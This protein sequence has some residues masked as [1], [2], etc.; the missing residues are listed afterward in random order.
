MDNQD[1]QGAVAI[2]GVAGRFSE[3]LDRFDAG[4]FGINHREAE[5]LD[6]QQRV[7]LEACWEALEDAGYGPDTVGLTGVFAGQPLSSYLLYNLLPALTDTLSGMDPLQLLV[8]N[9]A[10]SLAT[11]VSYKLN[12][13]GPSFTVQ[14]GE[15]TLGLAVHL[16]R[17]SLLNGECDLALAGWVSIDARTLEG[18][19]AVLVLK[20]AD[21]AIRD[22]D[23]VQGLVLDSSSDGLVEIEQAPEIPR[24]RSD[25]ER[26]V[27]PVSAR[28]PE[29][30]EWACQ[31]LAD[32][33]ETRPEVELADV[34][35]TL[36][37]GRK[38]FEH[39]RVVE[40]GTTQDAVHALR[41]FRG[42]AGVPPA[43]FLVGA[44]GTPALPGKARRISL[45]T[46]PFER[47]RY[48][49]EPQPESSFHPRPALFTPYEPPRDE[50][51][52][53][54]AA[55][56]QEVLGVAPVGAHDDFF[57]LGGHSLL[58][59]QIL[60]RVRDVFGV[61]FPL[62]HVFS[63][64]T[65]AEL[66][67]AIR[68]L[69]TEET[70]IPVSPRRAAGGPYPL[71]FAQERLWFIDRLDPGSP[72]YN[73]PRTALVSG[74]LDVPRFAAAL[75]EL[76]RRQ[77]ALRTTFQ[78]IDGEP[79]QVV[80]PAVDLVLPLVDLSALSE[81]QK[82]AE[83]LTAEEARRPFDLERGPVLRT[84][85]VRLKP[86]EHLV[87]FTVHH[88][89]SDGWS[90]DLLVGEVAALYAGNPLPE[91]PIQ[92][93]DYAEWQRGW[94]QDEVLEPHLAHWREALAGAP[95]VLEL[96]TDRPRPAVPSYRGGW[97]RM[98]LPGVA[99]PL[100]ELGRHEGASRF[101]TLLA[102]FQ[103]LLHRLTGQDDLLVGS[104]VAN[105][106][107]PEIEGLVGFFVNLLP[108]RARF[109]GET[110][111]RGLLGQVRDGAL[112]AYEHQDAPF[113]RVVE[114]VG[115][116]RDLSR[117]PLVQVL[118]L[119]QN[120]PLDSVHLPGLTL[121]A[122]EVHAGVARYDLS[123]FA[124]EAGGELAAAVEYSS[125]LF[126]AATV[127]RL[128]GWLGVLLRGA[129]AEPDASLSDLPLLD[130]AE[131]QQL[132]AEWNDAGERVEAGIVLDLFDGWVERT[133]E[134]P[135]VVSDEGSVTYREL[136]RRA[137]SLARHLRRL[138]VGP[139]TVIALQMERSPDLVTAALGV[140]R[141]GAAYLPL[142]PAYPAERL[143]WMVEDSGAK[144]R[145]TSIP[146]TGP[147]GDE[148]L[149]RPE[150][151]DLAYLIYTSG[152]T[153]RP[154]G[155]MVTH[156]GLPYLAAGQDRLL[157]VRPGDRVLQFSSPSFD[158]SVWE[159]WQALSH[160]AALVLGRRDELLPGPG[161]V[162]LLRRH[163]VTHATLPPS[164]LAAMPDGAEA[165]L[166]ALRTLCVA[167]EACPP[168]LARRWEA[169]RRFL[170]AYGPTEGTVC[171]AVGGLSGDRLPIGRPFA[172]FRL[173][174]VDARLAAVLIG[175]P[176]ELCLG[177]PGLA[178]GYLNR[179]DLTAERFIP[180]PFSGLSG[181]AGGRLYRTGDL[182]RRL[183]DG[184]LD[185]LGRIDHQV[186]IRGIRI[187]LGEIEAE[188]AAHP[189]VRQA[190][191]L[192]R[193]DRGERRL[194]AFVEA[195]PGALLLEADL[196][197]LLRGRLLEAMV[198]SAFVFLEALPVTPNG[199]VD[200]QA[201]AR[202]PV[203]RSAG[204]ST[205]ALTPTETVVA[206]I[207]SEL[208]GVG[209]VG[210]E[211]D[212]FALGGHS[213]LA[214]RVV[215]RIRDACGVELP[216]RALFEAPT[217]A[218]FAA[219][220]VAHDVLPAPPIQ[221]LPAEDRRAGLPL[222]FPQE[223]F[224]FLQELDPASGAYNITAAVRL[225]GR[226]DVA[227]LARAL[228]VLARRHEALRTVFRFDL[229]REEA[230]QQVL[231]GVEVRLPIVDLSGL[232]ELSPG[233][234]H[235]ELERLAAAAAARPFDL[236]RGPLLRATLVRLDAGEHALLLATHHIVSDGWSM[237][238]LVREVAA[239]YAGEPLPELP[240]QLGDYAVW[241]R[242]WLS[243]DV[244]EAQ[245]A[246][247]RREL[248][249]A[250]GLLDLPL[251]RPRP[252]VQSFRG[253]R[254]PV[255]L[256]AS[257]VQAL[258]ELGRARGATLFMVLLAGFQALLHRLS[259]QE[260]VLVGTPVANRDRTELE[261]LIGLLVNTLAL[262]ARFGPSEVPGFDPL[263]ERVRTTALGAFAH[264]DV[265][266]EKVLEGLRIERSLAFNP[267]FQHLF[268]LQTAPAPV[269]ALPG[270][271]LEPLERDAAALAWSKFDLSLSLAPMADGGLAGELEYAADLFDTS[272]V[273]HLARMYRT[274]LEA[275]AANPRASLDELVLL[276]RT[277][278]RQVRFAGS[279]EPQAK[280]MAAMAAMAESWLTEAIAGV[281]KDL[282]RVEH[283]GLSDNFF[284]LGGHSLLLPKLH[285]RLQEALGERAAGLKLADLFQFPTVGSLAAHLQGPGEE[286][287]PVRQRVALG[288]DRRIAIVGLAGRFHG[289]P[290]LNRFWE[291]LR[292]GV[293]SIRKLGREEL[294]IQGV[295]P[296]LIDDPAFVPVWSL[297]DGYD[298]FDARLFGFNPREAELLDPQHRVFLEVALEALE[299]AGWGDPGGLAV[300]VFAGT[301]A[302]AYL[303]R[304]LL[305]SSEVRSADPL[306]FMVGNIPDSLATRVSYKLDLQGPSYAVQSACSTS[307]LAVHAACQSLLMGECDMALAGGV[308]LP[309][310]PG[311]RH[312][313]NSI[314]SP[315]GHCRAFDAAALGTV[316]G[317]GAGAVV[318][319][320][321]EDAL[322]DGD[323]VR[324]VIL[325]SAVNNDGALKVGY[326][327]PSVEGQARVIAE[328]LATASVHPEEIAYVEAHG[329]ATPLGDTVEIAALTRAFRLRGSARSGYCAL[330]SVKS[331]LGHL[332]A[333][334]GVT[335][336]IK[337]VLSIEHG[338]IPPS[339][340]FARP[341]PQIDFEASPVYVNAG[342]QDWPRNGRPRRA[343][344]SSF[345]IGGTNVHIVLEE[346]PPAPARV[347]RE[348]EHLL[349]LSAHTASALEEVTARLARHLREHPDLDLGDVA[350]TLLQGRKAHR[351]RRT[352]R[353]RTLE[354]A[355]AA[356]ES[357]DPERVW[358]GV[359]EGPISEAGPRDGRRRIP[360]PTYP[361]ERERF[362]VDANVS[363]L[364]T[365]PSA[366][367][368]H[369]RP[370]LF[371][372]YVEPSTPAE[373]AVAAV[374]RE[375]LG[376]REV[377]VHDSFFEL[378][379]HSLL[380]TQVTA[381]LHQAFGVSLPLE[382]LF[383]H[384]TI[385]ELA[386]LLEGVA[387][388]EQTGVPRREP[389]AVLPLSFAQERLWFLDRLEPGSS[390]YNVPNAIRLT[391]DLDV[392]ALAAAL[393][394]VV[395]R[396]EMLRTAFREDA[397]GR[398]YQVVSGAVEL[399][400]P[401]IDVAPDELQGLAMAEA[402]RP[403]DL[404]RAPL[405]RAVLF[406]LGEREHVFLVTFH[407]VAADGWSIAVFVREIAAL[408]AGAELPELAVQYG[409]FALWQR[410]YL[411]GETLES[412]LRWWRGELAGAPAVLEL[413]ADRP[414][415]AEK[416]GRGALVPAG[417]PADLRASLE[418]LARREGATLFMV[419]LA[420]FQALL[421]RCNQ[422]DD[423]L[424]GTPVANR[425]L[426]ELEPIIGHF[427]NN[428]VMRGR[429]D[430][431]PDFR[432]L[433]GRTRAAALGAYDH[434]D[435]P[436]E[437]L[438]D[439]LKVERSLSHSPLFQVMLTLQNGPGLTL[440]LPGLAIEEVVFDPGIARY[441]LTLMLADGIGGGSGLT[442]T[443]E[444]DTDLFDPA[445]GERL[446]RHLH[447]LLSAVA[448]D[449]D[450]RLS[451]LPLLTAAERREVLAIGEA[452]EIPDLTVDRL[453]D[454]QADRTP[455]AVAVIQGET[456]LTYAGL[457]SRAEAIA[458]HLRSLGVGPEVRVGLAVDRTPDLLAAL[459]GIMK[460]GGAYVPLDLS[461][462]RERMAMIV[463][464]AKPAVILDQ[465]LLSSVE[466]VG[467]RFIA[468]S[469]LPD[470][471]AY[472]LFT[473]GS[474][475]RPKGVQIPHRAFVNFL[476]SM[477]REPG[478]SASD[479]LFAITTLSFDIAGL[480]LML[481]L[482]AGGR[483]ALATRDEAADA[484][485]LARRLDE[486]GAT[487][488]QATPATW[489]MLL[490]SDWEGKPDLAA[491]CGGEALPGE[492]AAR[493]RP[494]V[495]SLWNLY[496]PT[497]TTV[498]SAAG[499][500]ESPD[501]AL[502]SQPVGAPIAN[503]GLYVLDANREP[504][505]PGVPGELCIGGDGL[506]R[507]YV[508]RPELT[509]ER[510]VPD[511]FTGSGARMYRTG[512]LARRRAT[513][514][515]DF[516]GRIDH[517][518]KVRGFRIELGEIEAAL[519]SHP[520]VR[521]A[522]VLALGEGAEKTLTAYVSGVSS[523]DS[524]RAHLRSALPE[525]MIPSAF[526]FVESFPLNTNG[527][528]DRKA[529]AALKPQ[530]ETTAFVAPRTETERR[531]A[532]IWS[533]LL[534]AG[535]VGARD[536]FFDLGG[537]SLLGTQ[538]VSRVRVE[539]GVELPLRAL[540]EA[541]A[542]ADL[543][544]RIE[545]ARRS[546]LPP[547]PL[548]T[549][550][551]TGWPLSFAQE[552]LWFLD[553]LDAGASAYNVNSAVRL[554][555][556]LDVVRL[557][558]A[559]RAI[560]RR[561]EVLRT[562]FHGGVDGPVQVIHSEVDLAVPVIDVCGCPEEEIRRLSVEEAF[563]PFDLVHG[564]LMRFVLLRLG[565][566]EHLGLL[567]FHHIAADGWSTAVFLREV[568]ALYKGE[569]LPELAIQYA[570]FAVWQR[571]WLTGEVLEEQ[572]GWWRGE[573][574]GAPTVLDLPTDHP[575]PFHPSGRAWW[576]PA[577]L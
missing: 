15:S 225:R 423:V 10:D 218:G 48:W 64:P 472:I 541:P 247:W 258:Q 240:I 125:D 558:E 382:V 522:V 199:K 539:L 359:G 435:V 154:K 523:A 535:R 362:W 176:G 267:L 254:L 504:V 26:Y 394:A 326:S 114:A 486:V 493:L 41:A 157:D 540:F 388:E 101:M 337:T 36:T 46:Y 23:N 289:A 354:E 538:L 500:V 158:A 256:D 542:L 350:W 85:L 365:A 395:Q 177:G 61:D 20:R 348:E 372:A 81:P 349:V 298:R 554:E 14:A 52:A 275:A 189:G 411:Q 67:E 406:R 205:I 74:R 519:L 233:S 322:A 127:R 533:D 520:E 545:A 400:L 179:P 151:G 66:A 336:L 90:L 445:T 295:D 273:D 266:L 437:R 232:P 387:A 549:A 483:V 161:L 464:D 82:E 159:L 454:L 404:T 323:T 507:G 462:P 367:A 424:V 272:T 45:P 380:G 42:S 487:A 214:G 210:P 456:S 290:D 333:A 206:A 357:L 173:H 343:G 237:S 369:E 575:R 498:W 89:A 524:L 310:I 526:V 261:E 284:D 22:R 27:L 429:M 113:D 383:S 495:K 421:H 141:A 69:K 328:A 458:S 364:E 40:C 559:V 38:R 481:P 471:L 461:H 567:T 417:L 3:L 508:G 413:P 86:E 296:A 398:P 109:S 146:G 385:A 309:L 532:T 402:L 384:P 330:G 312:V 77:E 162:D 242:A 470:N 528:V 321:L 351:H 71:S 121:T 138:G 397:E 115:V 134:A 88:I 450:R 147:A 243:G 576:L 428:L 133:P 439:E 317:G 204:H 320:R 392:E 123:V 185:Y 305:A 287:A 76:V 188:L 315:D 452:A 415:P 311:Y 426:P 366:L 128:L 561:H 187:E 181:E 276:D 153:G 217:L 230:V 573:L 399:P 412:Q 563:R 2:V 137:D 391:G 186:K 332:D 131:R 294:E 135:A 30:L 548:R 484:V 436:F 252:P 375:L 278:R 94:L 215:A 329:T 209:S 572:L 57:Q 155:V 265:P 262:R 551:D 543:A 379:G 78:E 299:D 132:L 139:E 136:A 268:A 569:T 565:E 211:D 319:K 178:R 116:P 353:C 249:D 260:D 512:D 223:R 433:L 16:A 68:F 547:I 474:T 556:D 307:L 419:L 84:M 516:L 25:R 514:E 212:F 513:G 381:R 334:A 163:G 4:F 286:T 65:P 172:S 241:Q 91:L 476:L 8:G 466:G 492:L 264:Q 468:P 341:N 376:L 477:L 521:G 473:S 143:A 552:R 222:S 444:I 432:A 553:Q 465:E 489:R 171:S 562:T 72:L 438:V 410:E 509:A 165:E 530:E 453:F 360:L 277:E 63:F 534:G 427:V 31:W 269:L 80:S 255:A 191:A 93:A 110:T 497:E 370:A 100:D 463:E 503:T 234:R 291:N 62:Q 145:L 505:P 224:W 281:W 515:I 238:I 356:L 140:L 170:N 389:G 550:S 425:R 488:L 555:G 313:E 220:V 352:V 502:A 103:A 455:D 152:S 396:H 459:L 12:L 166:P 405:L 431:D 446:L 511:P 491:F 442:G 106:T 390:A 21:E 87:L 403:F 24:T 407:H 327:A 304:N 460:S 37:V 537:H 59:P 7:F 467:A 314:T 517:Q 18:E 490:D 308:S 183:P 228:D 361:F 9:A 11:R 105:R 301:G 546:L 339:L 236:G 373:R 557:A 374:W 345:G 32:W 129:L 219:R 60:G 297:P 197:A 169:G 70:S 203:G 33:L 104:P 175:V 250:P 99:G 227:G 79:W 469:N 441:D 482:L 518:V 168:A 447:T 358:T 167:G 58:A 221:A 283:V 414:R 251:D 83:R 303:L 193:E 6:P 422:A 316:P 107:R 355:V 55:I 149:P 144:L 160:G 300:G 200:R 531:L 393:R 282:L 98:P 34:E 386:S 259:G 443:L 347:V 13:K 29:A 566:W 92:Y 344:V 274:L 288:G 108:L 577:D 51:E 148:P 195:A 494:R 478:L 192:V 56:W 324:A 43:A 338:E 408:Y 124:A 485:L 202:M 126:E 44:G 440:E 194:V 401:V 28:S 409:D 263:L 207:W 239:L 180:D 271:V 257:L 201:L 235:A 111:F 246:W 54:V 335:G 430:G 285:A 130:P 420:G 73:E 510:F 449:P 506:A 457:R 150:P 501:P 196:R 117:P 479:T 292:G 174:V 568:V 164:V 499:A 248:A 190:V 325:G 49:I 229:D 480:E 142:D 19:A 95:T 245:L 451:D 216:L 371:T 434:Q 120:P 306:Q 184:Q 378:G 50:A 368:L 475:G 39:V 156:R 342:L 280:A 17:Q 570:D 279:A 536:S 448:A 226:L 5:I 331:N 253:G 231:P 122:R 318:L 529:L 363:R 346:A 244:L 496:G 574:A 525:Y 102:A 35:H 416:S 293:E 182:V 418:E 118:F 564:P 340:H 208:L 213:L 53:Q 119:L 302:S 560:V 544:A 97:E 75:R 47:R 1:L 112:R 96:P 198:P 270:L 377:G 527:K 571:E